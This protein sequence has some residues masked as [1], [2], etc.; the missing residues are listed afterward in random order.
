MKPELIQTRVGFGGGCHWC[1]EAVFQSLRGVSNVAQGFIKSHAPHDSY[2][3]AVVVSFDPGIIPLEVLTDVHLRTHSST[4]S[5]KM[6]GKYRSAVYVFSDAQGV[7]VRKQIDALQSDF[8]D[9]I[10]TTTLAFNGFKPSPEQF[11]DYYQ[12]NTD[13][14]FCQTYI[15]PK[16]R[17]IRQQFGNYYDPTTS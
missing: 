16:L 5:H 2:S 7:A 8:D 3:E 11:Q 9:A 15:D 13:K 4:S 14:P 6:R 17:K 1:T 10:V 12:T